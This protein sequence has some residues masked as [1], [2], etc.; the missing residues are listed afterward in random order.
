MLIS[1][2]SLAAFVGQESAEAVSKHGENLRPAARSETFRILFC[3]S[4]GSGLEKANKT[5]AC[6]NVRAFSHGLNPLRM[7]PG[8]SRY[9]SFAPD[10]GHSIVPRPVIGCLKAGRIRTKH[11]RS[12]AIREQS[13]IPAQLEERRSSRPAL[14]MKPWT[15]RVDFLAAGRL[16]HELP[17]RWVHHL[18]HA[19]R[20]H[21][22]GNE[23]SRRVAVISTAMPVSASLQES[24]SS[25]E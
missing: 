4:A 23:P 16:V 12:A 11:R 22:N 20:P 24:F 7:L 15:G 14:G 5:G 13:I 21:E 17:G 10:S 18:R 25:L 3:F 8:R 6:E 2:P 9:G 19:F 1:G